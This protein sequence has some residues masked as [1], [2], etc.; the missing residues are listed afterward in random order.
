MSLENEPRVSEGEL[1]RV[2]VTPQLP[3]SEGR[4]P[5][6]YRYYPGYA[7]FVIN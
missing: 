3:V 6:E 5:H 2:E 7:K 4:Y 1:G